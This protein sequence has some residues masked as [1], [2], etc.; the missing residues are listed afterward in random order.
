MEIKEVLLV[1]DSAEDRL[2]FKNHFKRQG[3][4]Q[5]LKELTRP[6]DALQ[7]LDGKGEDDLDERALLLIDIGLPQMDGLELASQIRL[8]PAWA[9][10]P[11]IMLTDSAHTDH[12]ARAKALNVTGYMLKEHIATSMSTPDSLLNRLLR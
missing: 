12:V 11:I 9:D 3:Y 10:V 6:V 4:S 7:T 8:R 2:I 5:K 1:D